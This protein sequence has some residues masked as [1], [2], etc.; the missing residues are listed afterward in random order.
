[1]KYA[2]IALIGMFLI[3]GFNPPLLSGYSIKIENFLGENIE[4]PVDEKDGFLDVMGQLQSYLEIASIE[5]E[6]E[7]RP[8]TIFPSESHSLTGSGWNVVMMNAGIVVKQKKDKWRSYENGATKE[9]K[10]N[11]AFIVKTLGFESVISIGKEKSSLERTGKKIDHVHPLIFLKT[12]FTDEELKAGIAAIRDR[13]SWVKNGFFDGLY[14][15]LND[16]AERD[17]L[18]QHVT[19]FAKKV[20]INEGLIR[21]SLEKK[22]WK[23]FVSILIDNIPREKDPNRYNM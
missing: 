13:V 4:I 16:E 18:M 17:N 8:L 6:N 11:I 12:V 7:I 23:E 2:S 10:S 22:K 15:S 14:E 5:A 3:G 1:M 20:K 21:S 9:E 19:D